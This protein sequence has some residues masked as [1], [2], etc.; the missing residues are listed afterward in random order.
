MG[1][2][3]TLL[4]IG[5]IYYS[6]KFLA[7]LFAPYLMK[8]AMSKMEEKM[9]NQN[10]QATN[11]NDVKIGETVIDKKPNSTKQSDKSVGEYIDFEELD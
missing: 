1:L 8:K 3:K 2:I 10:R 5:I 11:K 7:R 9:R 6:F 4:I